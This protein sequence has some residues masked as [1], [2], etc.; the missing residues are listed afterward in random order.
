MLCYDGNTLIR[1]TIFRISHQII[2]IYKSL[3]WKILVDL[4]NVHD[5][6]EVTTHCLLSQMEEDALP[7]FWENGNNSTS[8]SDGPP[9]D[10][11]L[12]QDNLGLRIV[13]ALVLSVIL[14]TNI[15]ANTLCICVLRRVSELNP[16]TKAFLINMTV[17]DLGT[18][19]IT[20]THII[21]A[22]IVNDWPYGQ[23]FCD[24]MGVCNIL[25]SFTALMSLLNVNL[26]RYL[27]VMRP[28]D[29]HRLITLGRARFTIGTLWAT[30]LII[31]T[32]NV[33]LPGRVAT[34]A[35]G[36]HTCTV[37]PVDLEKID[38]GGSFLMCLFIIVPFTITLILFTRLFLLARF[39]ANRIAD[40]ERSTAT[41][42]S[43]QNTKTQTKA[44]TTFFIMTMCLIFCY[45]PLVISFGYENI[46]REE[47][48]L[49][50]VYLAE[51]LTFSNSV[52][53]VIIYYA[54]NS[55]FRNTAKRLIRRL[56][57][58]ALSKCLITR[59]DDENSATHAS[60]SFVN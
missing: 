8:S 43:A 32:L 37:G 3:V 51:I 28:F 33:V 5:V 1:V 25:F 11:H 4:Y 16:V 27:A 13:K 9:N 39:H 44:F 60:M 46:T 38:I 50:F 22:I 34:F 21:G 14:L 55:T 30:S 23:V 7:T 6:R 35:P 20:C 56:L 57:P 18:G 52:S 41:V 48:P 54:R 58:A 31:A 19:L 36:L 2:N 24:M 47:L 45:T 40:L 15:I 26:E 10:H 59:T 29:Y 53:N 17:S 49:A 42:A 12:N